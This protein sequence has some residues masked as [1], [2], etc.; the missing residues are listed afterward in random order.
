MGEA[1]DAFN[2]KGAIDEALAKIGGSAMQR[3]NDHWT[4]TQYVS[5]RA[6]KMNWV[7]GGYYGNKDDASYV[8]AVSA[9]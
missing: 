3:G 8:R 4:S 7:S 2:N 5:Y 9:L 6:W 1:Q